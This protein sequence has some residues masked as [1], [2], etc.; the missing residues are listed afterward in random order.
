LCRG[1]S[2]TIR[3]WFGSKDAVRD[4]LHQILHVW[5]TSISI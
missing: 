5:S 4:D 1:H 3:A 2:D